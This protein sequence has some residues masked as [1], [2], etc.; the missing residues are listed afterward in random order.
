MANGGGIIEFESGFQR[1]GLTHISPSSINL[2]IGS[3]A[4]WVNR[5]LFRR[6]TPPSPAMLR[7][8]AVENGVTFAIKRGNC[9]DAI[10]GGIELALEQFD[11][12]VVIDDGERVYKER[13]AI[14]LMITNAVHALRP[15]GEPDFPSDMAQHKVSGRLEYDGGSVPVIGFLDYVFPKHGIVVDLKATLR[16]NSKM[17]ADHVRQRAVYSKLSPYEDVRF[18]YT[19]KGK[20]VFMDDG[21]PDAVI[22]QMKWQVARLDRILRRFDRDEIRDLIPVNPDDYQWSDSAGDLSEIYAYPV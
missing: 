20:A 13:S 19:T 16:L 11:E 10:A 4:M 5:Y 2:W 15:F 22:E 7:G 6:T 21:E 14:P 9:G 17:S 3:P 12:K 18:L 8:I 1:H